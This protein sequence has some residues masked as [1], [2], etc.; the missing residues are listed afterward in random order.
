MANLLAERLDKAI[1]LKRSYPRILSYSLAIIL[2]ALIITLKILISWLSG[3]ATSPFIL[4]L[5]VVLL[6]AWFGGVRPGIFATALTTLSIWYFFLSPYFS[7][8]VA[9]L[10]RA[11][12]LEIMYILEC[13]FVIALV[14]KRNKAHT[15]MQERVA[16]QSVV[17]AI[18]QHG[19]EEKDLNAFMDRVSRALATTLDVKFVKI[20]ELMPDGKSLRLSSGTGWRRGI[21]RKTV[22]MG[23]LN[24][25]AGYALS[26]NRPIITT[27]L[28]REKR[29]R[30]EK[31]LIDHRIISGISVI[32]PGT[33]SPFGVLSVHSEKKRKFTKEDVTFV[34]SIAHVVSTTIE[35]QRIR[36][37]LELMAQ[38]NSKMISSL[39]PKETLQGFTHLVVPRFADV[40]EIYLKKDER[41]VELVNVTTISKEKDYLF[42]QISTHYPPVVDSKRT[43]A[44]V[45]RTGRPIFL[46]V[47]PKDYAESIGQDE[48]HIQITRKLNFQSIMVHPLKIRSKTIGAIGFGTVD[49]GRIFTPREF[50]LG[51]EISNRLAVAV[52]NAMLYQEA[53][54]AV[55]ARDEFLSIASHE[56]KTPLTSMLLQLQS[57]LHSMKNQSLANFS[58]EKTMQMIESTIGQ[59]KRLSKLVNDLLNISLITTG[60]LELELEKTNLTKVTKDVIDRFEVSA[61][62]AGSHISFVAQGSVMGKWDKIRIE[63]AIT[64]LVTNAIKY[65]EGKDIQVSIRKEKDNAVVIVADNGNGIS[66]DQQGKIFNRFERGDVKSSIQ[67]LGVGLYLV[68]EIVK[69]HGGQIVVESEVGKGATFSITLPL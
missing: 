64:N 56:L 29:F 66:R 5:P 42:K 69:A 6:S 34:R 30:V 52:D 7:F 1:L 11:T 12:F 44:K 3:E 53:K 43:I 27:D 49:N 17:A 2:S 14:Y 20:L 15:I 41:S 46:P 28:T 37:E 33:P 9:N 65:G 45:M 59:S 47:V 10:H 22:L 58:I 23:D 31:L 24:S 50:L 54:N 67:G 13:V 60:R 55:S 48:R 61:K 39:D 8:N 35:R 38:V 25:Q 36:Q 26:S 62:K 4:F 57:V 32:V 21:V 51:K 40:C 19:L 16:Q 68:S 63:Q 18:G